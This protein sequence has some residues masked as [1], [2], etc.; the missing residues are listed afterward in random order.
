MRLLLETPKAIA[1]LSPGLLRE[2]CYWLL[3]GPGGVQIAA[4]TLAHSQ[5]RS[6]LETIHTLRN[7]FCETIRIHDLAVAARMSPATFHRQFKSVT[8]MTPLQYQK[9]L[10]LL[11]ARRLMITSNATVETAA[12]RVGYESPSQ[13]SREYSRTF[14]RSPRRDLLNSGLHSQHSP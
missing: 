10:R 2:I 14:G 3:T 12:L 9:Q 4:V 8:A 11:E 5:E 13:F 1:A 6:I 7:R